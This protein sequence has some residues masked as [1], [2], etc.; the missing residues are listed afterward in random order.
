MVFT[1]SWDR[2]VRGW[3]PRRPSVPAAV[4]SLGAKVFCMDAGV[5]RLV[6]GGS[7]RHMH[8]YDVRSLARP[9]ERRESSLKHQVRSVQVGMGQRGY[10][11]CSVEGRVALEYFE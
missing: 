1:G 7:D 8:I 5:D 9:L 4:I 6:V 11:S 3:D 10:A 2:T